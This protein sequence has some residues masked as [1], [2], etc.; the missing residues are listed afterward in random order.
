[1]WLLTIQLFTHKTCK[2]QS[3]VNIETRDK[4]KNH[5]Q[6]FSMLQLNFGE[7]D[8]FGTWGDNEDV[9]EDIELNIEV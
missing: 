1:M 3:N 7:Q 6:L 5:F 8:D 2:L 4:W 9:T